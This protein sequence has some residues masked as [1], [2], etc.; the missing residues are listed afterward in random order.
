MLFLKI[1]KWFT[2][3]YIFLFVNVRLQIHSLMELS[4]FWETANCAATQELLSILWN[5]KVHY[6]VHQSPPLAP[7]LSNI[8]P[9]HTIPSY[10]RSILILSTH[11]R[12]D[13]PSRL[14]PSGFP[15]NILYAFLFSPICATCP[16]RLI[17]NLEL[18]TTKQSRPYHENGY[19][20]TA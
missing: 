17:S 7:I 3:L 13:L 19:R 5:P 6:R 14:F 20:Y 1:A 10:R 2:N 9:I 15:T 8:N 16:V 11:L 12:F 4:P 18:R